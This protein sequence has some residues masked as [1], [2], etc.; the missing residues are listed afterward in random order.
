MPRIIIAII[1]VHMSATNRKPT[2]ATPVAT[3]T[4]A[5]TN[6]GMQQAIIIHP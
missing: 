4:T 2:L 3:K 6:I 5:M 1:A